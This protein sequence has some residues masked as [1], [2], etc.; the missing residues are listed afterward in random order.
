MVLR[1]VDAP[2]S[3]IRNLDRKGLIEAIK[4]SDGRTIAA[5]VV[6]T[7][8]PLVDKIS[9][10][11]IAAGFGADMIILNFY[12][13]NL[14][15]IEGIPP[16]IKTLKQLRDFLGRIV[17]LNLEPVK[18]DIAKELGYTPGRLATP[19]NAKKA[20]EDGADFLVITANPMAKVTLEDIIKA[21]EEIRNEIGDKALIL[22]GKMHLAGVYGEA[23][24][25][26]LIKKFAEAGADGILIPAPGTVP[27]I[28]VEIAK[29]LVDEAH[30]NDLLV[31]STIGTSQEGTDE[32]TIRQIGLL[33][34]MTG[35][36][37]HH[38]GDSGYSSSVAMPENIMAYSIVIRGKRHTYRRIAMSIMR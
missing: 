3:K 22:A 9:N 34:K 24:T 28:T 30:K 4:L 20:V 31:M 38:I 5:E 1:L 7:A 21:T 33:S 18:E 11:E 12:D 26:K 36:D 2:W 14:K 35:A 17:G 37:I 15:K 27:G 23:L 25:P 16:E 10:L 13:V 29:K 19:E 32:F 6:V 8:K